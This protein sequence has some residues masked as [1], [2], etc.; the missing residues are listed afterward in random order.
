MDR[1]L[2]YHANG[3]GFEPTFWRNFFL[4]RLRPYPSLE[5]VRGQF[6]QFGVQ[7]QQQEHCWIIELATLYD[8]RSLYIGLNAKSP[9]KIDLQRFQNAKRQIFS[10]SKKNFFFNFF[11]LILVKTFKWDHKLTIFA[12]S[13][14]SK[15]F[16]TS[17]LSSLCWL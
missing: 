10:K 2:G 14:I 4:F 6:C 11:F 17:P 1:T 13:G 9:S 16:Y 3:H 5:D 12:I 15:F 8:P 7:V